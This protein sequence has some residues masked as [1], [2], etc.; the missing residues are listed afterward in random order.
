MGGEHSI[1]IRI[2]LLVTS[3]IR[4]DIE[5]GDN[6]DYFDYFNFGHPGSCIV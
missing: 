5:D 1:M 6:D 2:V 4:F 3:W